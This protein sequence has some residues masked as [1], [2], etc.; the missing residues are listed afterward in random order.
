MTMRRLLTLLLLT[1]LPACDVEFTG[2]EVILRHDRATD[3]IDLMLIYDGLISEDP[4]EGADAVTRLL[5]GER[6]FIVGAWPLHFKL[7]EWARESR[8]RLADADTSEVERKLS[9]SFVEIEERVTS[10]SSGLFTDEEGALHGWQH[11]RV[12]QATRVIELLNEMISWSVLAEVADGGLE[13]D[14][15]ID[16]RTIELWT[17]RA[18]S[19]LPW[20]GVDGGRI[21]ID[22]PVSADVGAATAKQL[23]LGLAKEMDNVFARLLGALV[24]DAHALALESERLRVELRAP[25]DDRFEWKFRNPEHSFSPGLSEELRQRGV[26]VLADMTPDALK[27]RVR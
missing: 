3:T 16:A 1:L 20:F 23:V 8:E 11:F 27:N 12:R 24:G 7:D 21:V 6:E 14:D 22:V 26:A 5:D 2:Q 15:D 19:G 18:S 17:E 13:P 10:V 4:A 9:A 25:N